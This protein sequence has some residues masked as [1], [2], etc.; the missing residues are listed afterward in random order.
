M[1]SPRDE[2]HFD[3]LERLLRLERDEELRRH[4][5]RDAR[6]TPKERVAQ[7]LAAD[8][9]EAT[10]ERWTLGG[11]LV[12]TYQRPERQRIEL[13]AEPGTPVRL[14]PRRGED[15]TWSQAVVTKRTATELALAFNAAPPAFA[16]QGRVWLEPALSDVT[17]R[18]C[19][20]AI[21]RARAMTHGRARDRREVLLG[22]APPRW[23]SPPTFHLE[24]ALNPEQRHAVTQALAASDFCLVHGPPGTGKTTVLGEVA[25]Q[26]VRSGQRVLATAASNAAV[27]NLLDTC[28][29]RGLR[30]LRIGHPARVL[31]RLQQHTLDVLIEEHPD[32]VLA[33]ELLDEAHALKGYARR[34][35]TQGRS[36]E[37][38][39]QAHQAGREAGALFAEARRLERRAS[40]SLIAEADVV[41]VTLTVFA[42]MQSELGELGLVL[43]DEATQAI[44]PLALWAWHAADKVVLAGDHK[45]LPPTVLSPRAQREGL[46]RSLFERLLEDHGDA[47][48]VMLREQ[49]RMSEAIMRFPSQTMYEG[50][51]RAHEAVAERTLTSGS[52]PGD[53]PLAPDTLERARALDAT[54]VLFIDTAGKG[55]DEDLPEGSDSK[56]NPGEAAILISRLVELLRAGFAA[57]E[58]AI[59]TPYAAQVSELRNRAR[60]VEGAS[61]VEIDTV[62]AFQGREKDVVLL[63]LV[64]SNAA[65]ELGFLEDL[66]R[67][68]VAV[69][70]PRRQ[71][72]V[73]G[74]SGTLG[75]HPYFHAFI[76]RAHELAGYRSAWE[77][78]GSP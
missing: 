1:P 37:R 5:E 46:G 63:S 60:V 16:T 49:Y 36:R 77:W 44:E 39:V 22:R 50:A 24:R 62:D 21:A 33:R 9:L 51:L 69:S 75:Q 29:G 71:L 59:I 70:R 47:T 52:G 6:L 73:V 3:E 76:E 32:F 28:V 23:S 54:P 11:R 67:M 61:D 57:S 15:D 68:N 35:R 74:D 18:R 14:K 8:D 40:A 4:D 34:Q 20:E 58:I 19:L 48:R 30:A 45:Q 12:V 38:H 53:E 7:G 31:E 10:D 13:A 65:G 42:G 78:P 25:V 26:A 2:R 17:F 64:R 66:R 43:F 56:R 41:C 72:F 27:D 55:F